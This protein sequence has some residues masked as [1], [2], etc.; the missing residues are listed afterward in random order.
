MHGDAVTGSSYSVGDVAAL[1]R[2]SVRTLHHYDAIGLLRPSGRTPAGHRRYTTADLQRLREIVFYREL[3]F[4]LEEIA[5]MLD[6]PGATTEAHLRSQHRMLRERI[7]RQQQ[8]LAALEKQMEASEMGISLSPEEQ[9]ELFGTD[10]TE[11]YQQEAEQRWGDTEAWKQSHRRAAAYTK[12]D[13]QRIKAE[14]DDNLAAFADA[15]RAGEAADGERARTL[16]EEHRT[17]IG[18]WFYDCSYQ[19]HQRLGETYVS[20]PRFTAT[21]E[22]VQPGL[23]QY[24]CDAVRANAAA[25]G[26]S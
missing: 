18:R 8:L 9:F 22:Q 20:D 17:H 3:D 15:L 6:D 25:H 13:W 14:A 23:A 19:L 7:G 4:G 11:E 5:A 1:A 2:V 24:V 12:D 16:A 10:K 26:V 21:Y